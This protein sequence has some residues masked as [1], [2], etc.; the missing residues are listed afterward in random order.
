MV[1]VLDGGVVTGPAGAPVVL[2]QL[3]PGS[4]CA[5]GGVRVTQLIDGGVVDVCNGAAGPS[6]AVSVLPNMSTQCPRV[7]S[8]SAFLTV[9]RCRCAMALWARRGLKAR[10][11]RRVLLALWARWG[12]PVR[13]E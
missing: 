5:T 8:S 12:L 13:R 2:T 4:A 1:L 9:A 11:V 3:S 6:P 7:A 10:R